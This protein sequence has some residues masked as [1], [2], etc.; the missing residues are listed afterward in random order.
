MLRSLLLAAAIAAAI[1]AVEV[2]G[3]PDAE[4]AFWSGARAAAQSALGAVGLKNI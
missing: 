4:A 1:Y 2:H 3:R